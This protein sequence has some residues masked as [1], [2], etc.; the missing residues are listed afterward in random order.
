[1]TVTFNKT[2]ACTRCNGLEYNGLSPTRRWIR[3]S[4]RRDGDGSEQ[5]FG[6][7]DI[8]ERADFGAGT[9]GT[10]FSAAGT[11][12]T[13]RMINSFGG[14]AEDKIVNATGS[15]N[16]TAHDLRAAGSCRWR[17]SKRLLIMRNAN[18]GDI[19]GCAL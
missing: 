9:S 7:H 8:C 12:F 1:M 5:R 3:R 10:N 17:L 16:A 6:D 15:Y 11:G 18:A 2:A 19:L 14:I 13:S 4:G